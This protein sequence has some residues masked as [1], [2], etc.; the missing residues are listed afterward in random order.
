MKRSI[1]NENRLRIVENK[2]EAYLIFDRKTGEILEGN[3]I[4]RQFYCYDGKFMPLGDLFFHSSSKDIVEENL[5][6][7]SQDKILLVENVVSNK[8]TGEEFFCDIEMEF[9]DNEETIVSITIIPM[10]DEAIHQ[11]QDLVGTAQKPFF[12]LDFNKKL[13]VRSANSM[14]YQFFAVDKETFE[15]KHENSFVNLARKENRDSFVL[16]VYDTLKTEN[17]CDIDVELEVKPN[18]YTLFRFNIH[19]LNISKDKDLLY[20][21]VLSLERRLQLME[22]NH[23]MQRR[24]DVV[25]ELSANILFYIDLKTK[26]LYKSENLGGFT[27]VVPIIDNYPDPEFHREIVFRDDYGQYMV[28][29]ENMAKGV[30]DSHIARLKVPSGKY[31]YFQI[32]CKALLDN[33][34]NAVE[35]YGKATNIQMQV[36]LEK[37]AN[38]DLLTNLLNK[39]RFNETVI[40]ILEKSTDKMSHALLFVDL[41][42]FKKVNDSLGHIFGDFLLTAV[43]KRL[44]RVV[45]GGDLIGRVG[46]DEFVVFLPTL[47][48]ETLAVTRAEAIIETLCREFYNDGETAKVRASIGIAIYPHHGKDYKE[49]YRCADKALY[50]SKSRGKNVVTVYS[51]DLDNGN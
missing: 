36:E 33:K 25:Q 37:K 29:A 49:L 1:M 46:G 2:P 19:R 48:D 39:E 43:G 21:L 16:T 7:F 50:K 45:R 24:F 32:S 5:L 8:S 3:K 51:K 11:M 38:Y 42:D 34:G 6:K 18:E 10:V 4:A 17:E 9:Y 40:E 35:M 28:F 13:T 27:N 47:G 30:E 41:D 26:I 31:E 14:F 20:G 23:V 22:E 12:I 44:K 15:E